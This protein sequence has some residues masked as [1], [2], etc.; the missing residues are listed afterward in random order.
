MADRSPLPPD[1][2]DTPEDPPATEPNAAVGTDEAAERMRA[3]VRALARQ[4]ARDLWAGRAGGSGS[5]AP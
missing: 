2:P 4:A 3:L 5:D 1:R